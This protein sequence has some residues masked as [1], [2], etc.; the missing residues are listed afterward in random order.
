MP[1]DE[2]KT[3]TL[4]LA[5][6]VFKAGSLYAQ[7]WDLQNE[8]GNPCEPICAPSYESCG[9]RLSLNRFALGADFL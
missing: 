2:E 3:T 6:R 5:S 7:P 4:Y 1:R 8:G 9:D